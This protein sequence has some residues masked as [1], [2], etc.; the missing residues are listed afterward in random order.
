MPGGLAAL[1]NYSLI[2]E[3]DYAR[4]NRFGSESNHEWTIPG[5][6]WNMISSSLKGGL[7]LKKLCGNIEI[8]Q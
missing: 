8:V 7:T 4:R 2:I 5:E 3:G 1:Y 6:T